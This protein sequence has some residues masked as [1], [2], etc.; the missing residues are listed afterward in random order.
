MSAERLAFYEMRI[1][2]LISLFGSFLVIATYFMFADLRRL[3]YIELVFYV[4]INDAIASIGKSKQQQRSSNFV[5]YFIPHKF[6][7]AA[8]GP[9]PDD[10]F[11][12]WF[13]GLTTTANYVS[14]ALWTTVIGEFSYIAVEW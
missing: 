4:S 2:G 8:L 11:A 10:T 5:S 14:S 12:C 9:V 3:R 1:T 6:V 7:G 13:Q